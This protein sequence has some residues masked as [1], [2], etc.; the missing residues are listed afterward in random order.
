MV[1]KPCIVTRPGRLSRLPV[2]QTVDPSPPPAWA[3]GPPYGV[4][5]PCSPESPMPEA[6]EVRWAQEAYAFL[7]LFRRVQNRLAGLLM[8]Q[9]GW[10]VLLV[11]VAQ[12]AGKDKTP[13]LSV[14]G[15]KALQDIPLGTVYLPGAFL[16]LLWWL[17]ASRAFGLIRLF[18]LRSLRPAAGALL[19]LSWF[20]L[21]FVTLPY[22]VVALVVETL[23]FNAWKKRQN[24]Q[25][26]TEYEPELK[27]PGLMEIYQEQTKR[28][29]DKPYDVVAAWIA[30]T[31]LN[32]ASAATI[33]LSPFYSYSF[34]EEQKS[35]KAPM[36]VFATAIAR[37][38]MALGELPT[39]PHVGFVTAP[40]IV[41]ID[42]NDRAQAVVRRYGVDTLLWGSYVT[43]EPPRIWLNIQTR[44]DPHP[45]K[46]DSDRRD[47]MDPLV[48]R[49]IVDV[50][51][52]VD[53]DDT[54]DAYIV[55]LVSYLRTL[56]WRKQV[57]WGKPQKLRF[58]QSEDVLSWSA[59][60]RKTVF[61]SLIVPLL[62]SLPGPLVSTALDKTPREVLIE[63][64]SDW[65]VEQMRESW[66]SDR[67]DNWRLRGIL[68]NCIRLR[69]DV[70]DHH[71]RLGA[72]LCL[73]DDEPAA[74]ASFAEGQA[75]DTRFASADRE[76][77]S[78]MAGVYLRLMDQRDSTEKAK[79]VAY[80]A[81]A[82]GFGGI[83]ARERLLATLKDAKELE[84]WRRIRE[85]H[86]EQKDTADRLL[87]RLLHPVAAQP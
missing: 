18:A 21:L 45:E 63:Y 48:T 41:R 24:P 40:D 62:A 72:L 42:S 27:E 50:M 2:I 65:A 84:L 83:R 20:V 78:I 57:R 51:M 5:F 36:Q 81:R 75:L 8:M 54:I 14:P 59:S 3:A 7:A 60:D 33:A 16:V 34:E 11:L 44:P 17:F 29:L 77:I 55:I 4:S 58:W 25:W 73:M 53:Q 13:A 85:Q 38:R 52:I 64:A 67:V 10:A 70:P 26:L 39:I 49:P 74:F 80:V 79:T 28:R 6:G 66:S 22:L 37:L 82:L 15:I 30:R 12:F 69:P 61:V 68:E 1:K 31:R 76:W 46:R 71:Y 56:E 47:A 87:D 43:A 86:P 35:A 23:R 9:I 32:I 19:W